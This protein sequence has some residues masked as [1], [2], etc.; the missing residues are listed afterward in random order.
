MIFAAAGVSH[1]YTTTSSYLVYNKEKF[2]FR[3]PERRC[4]S[5]MMNR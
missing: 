1:S 5:C 4:P 2:P 3:F